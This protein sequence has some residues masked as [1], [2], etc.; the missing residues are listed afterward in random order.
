MR[1][2][3][4]VLGLAAG[5]IVWWLVDQWAALRLFRSPH[6]VYFL[7]DRKGVVLYVG[8]TEDAM[9]RFFEHVDDDEPGE[10]RKTIYDI[11][12][13]RHCRSFRQSARIERRMIRALMDG[14]RVRMCPPLNN[15]LLVGRPLV[16]SPSRW[17]WLGAYWLNGRLMPACR[18]HGPNLGRLPG[19]MRDSQQTALQGDGMMDSIPYGPVANPVSNADSPQR[20]PLGVREPADASAP[21]QPDEPAPT[22]RAP[23][24]LLPPAEPDQPMDREAK[25]RADNARYQR[26]ARARRAAEK[27]AAE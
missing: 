17:V 15:L 9:R 13:V 16:A 4:A 6:V 26:E 22:P 2:L 7:V 18:W 14:S 3:L 21:S 24:R 25:R 1:V 20:T 27:R 19:G 11:V 12:I 23:L 10:W 8:R 5:S